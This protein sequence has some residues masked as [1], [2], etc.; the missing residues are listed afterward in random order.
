MS[1]TALLAT[2]GE[3]VVYSGPGYT[4]SKNGGVANALVCTSAGT[5]VLETYGLGGSLGV[6]GN[7]SLSIAMVAG[8]IL[9]LVFVKIL[10]SSTGQ[11]VALF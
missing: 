2:D 10:S 8:Q 6:P 11:F 3:A 7:A 5:V 4:P 1:S 9:P